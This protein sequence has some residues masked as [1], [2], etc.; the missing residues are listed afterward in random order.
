[1]YII[2]FIAFFKRLLFGVRE[3]GQARPDYNMQY[4][5]R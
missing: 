4:T 3:G 5:M 1:M 2:L